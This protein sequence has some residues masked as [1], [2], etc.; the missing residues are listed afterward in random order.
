[1]V[2]G[3]EELSWWKNTYPRASAGV[4]VVRSTAKPESPPILRVRV[5]AVEESLRARYA[6]WD[7]ASLEELPALQTYRA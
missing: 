6:S 5:Q 1:V 3:G 2:G 4:L 7:L